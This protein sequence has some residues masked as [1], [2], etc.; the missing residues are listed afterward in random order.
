MD[1][2]NYQIRHQKWLL[3]NLQQPL[4]L[5]IKNN[6]KRI[7]TASTVIQSSPIRINKNELILTST[8]TILVLFPTVTSTV[9]EPLLIP[10]ITPLLSTVAIS[11]F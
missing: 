7:N 2:S 6:N 4:N 5:Y 10:V 9:V 11:E 8:L 3:L 1:F